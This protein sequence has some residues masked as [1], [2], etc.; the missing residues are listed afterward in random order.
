LVNIIGE[1]Q[2][3]KYQTMNPIRVGPTLVGGKS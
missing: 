1:H 3:S 2:F